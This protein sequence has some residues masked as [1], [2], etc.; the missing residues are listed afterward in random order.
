MVKRSFFNLGRPK[1]RY[2][3]IAA[4]EKEPVD[5]PLPSMVFVRIGGAI[6]P[7]GDAPIRVGDRVRTGQRIGLGNGPRD[8]FVAPV[9][10]SICGISSDTGYL[11]RVSTLIAV[12]VAPEDQ[13]DGEFAAVARTPKREGIVRYLGALP[14]R[15]DLGAMLAAGL[16]VKIFVISG[17]DKD[18]LITANQIALK[19]GNED[20]KEGIKIL[21]QVTGAERIILLLPPGLG[22]SGEGVEA[23]WKVV[24]AVYPQLLSSLV[25]KRFLGREVP[26][27]KRCEDLGAGFL[28]AETVIALG[29]AFREGKI[30]VQKTLTVI[31]KD[32]SATNVRARVGTPVKDILSALQI[33]TGPGDRVILGG[34]MTGQAVHSGQTPITWDTDGIL[35]QDKEGGI[36]PSDSHCVNCGECVRACPAKV[37]VNM[38]IRY[39]ENRLY[40]DAVAQYDLLSCVEC[41]LCS[42]VCVAHIPLFQYI[43]L[44]KNEY[45]VLKSAEASNA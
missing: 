1:L 26:A 8:Y 12:D 15:S 22:F 4:H 16:A 2:A 38:L 30:P 18:L 42:Y 27:G 23:E 31:R 44:G 40:E 11:G 3:S 25:M 39:L 6:P 34:P 37:P 14:G 29:R 32:G 45:A 36:H 43:M 5:I 41:G 35:V 17:V 9:T 13:W 7:N 19:N 20:L 21:R 33:E 28:S 10:G 24:D